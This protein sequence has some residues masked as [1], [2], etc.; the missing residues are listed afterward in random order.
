MHGKVA[1]LPEVI[2][3]CGL[4]QAGELHVACVKNRHAKA[5]A[6]ADNHFPMQLDAATSYVGDYVHVPRSLQYGG[7]SGGEDGWA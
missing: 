1:K 7:W 4:T 3:S 6:N 5:D 2:I